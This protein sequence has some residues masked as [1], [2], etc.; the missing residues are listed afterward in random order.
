MPKAD[1]SR[2]TVTNK[3]TVVRDVS[4]NIIGQYFYDGEGKRV[5]KITNTETTIFV[6]S[7]GKLIAEYSTQL[8]QN[9][10][11]SYTT[12]DHLGSPRIITDQ[13]GQVKSRRDFMPF[14][15]DLFNG[16]GPR[17]ESLKYGT[18]AD[19]V[20][21]KFTGYLKDSETGL[22]FAEARMYENRHG[23]FTAV[24]P[25]LASGKSSNPQTFNRFVYVGNNPVNITDPLGLD[26]WRVR[27]KNSGED[28]I[29]WF[30]GD[31]NKE[32]YDSIQ[33][34]ENYVYK[35]SDGFWHALDPNSD[36]SSKWYTEE[37]ARWDYG[38]YSNYDGYGNV[39]VYGTFLLPMISGIKTGNV[40]RAIY[41]F[42]GLFITL[43][44]APRT[45]GGL[46]KEGASEAFSSLSGLPIFNFRKPLANEELVQKAAN[47]A[48]KRIDEVGRFGG[49][50]KHAYS[51]ELLL[52]HQRRFGDNGLRFK[53]YFN[54]G[55]GNRGFLGKRP[56][57]C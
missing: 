17:T 55:P 14:G 25:L 37:R 22:D 9:P 16:V 21:Q 24:D 3:Q 18:N 34:W 20:K 53:Q 50:A 52:R 15:E 47:I 40:E 36:Y 28:Q 13:F 32:E 6:Y 57:N 19:D 44:T 23:R 4:N 12:T 41:G 45:I 30:D 33:K 42:E 8:S 51:T 43:A 38:A 31:P 1:S 48:H 54:N 11:I 56:N 35:A 29:R 10:T 27:A 49:I 7:A 39:P 2:S 46:L 5:K 26:W